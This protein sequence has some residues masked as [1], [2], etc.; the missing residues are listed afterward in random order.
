MTI[1]SNK[2]KKVCYII[3]FIQSIYYVNFIKNDFYSYYSIFDIG[4]N[5]NEKCGHPGLL[6]RRLNKVARKVKLK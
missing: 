2:V 6:Y 3:I 1:L 4:G 5:F